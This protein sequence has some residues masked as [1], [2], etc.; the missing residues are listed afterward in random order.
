MEVDKLVVY[1]I[2]LGIEPR[3]GKEKFVVGFTYSFTNYKGKREDKFKEIYFPCG[4]KKRTKNYIYKKIY[5]KLLKK[6]NLKI[7]Y[8]ENNSV[9][10]PIPEE[11]YYADDD[12]NSEESEESESESESEESESEN[13]DDIESKNS[14]DI[15]NVT[16]IITTIHLDYNCSR[17]SQG[18]LTC[19]LGKNISGK[20]IYMENV[21]CLCNKNGDEVQHVNSSL[22]ELISNISNE[23]S[24]EKFQD[25]SEE[26]SK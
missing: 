6:Y 2:D 9:Y 24:R 18:S 13:D 25:I 20:Y 15:N 3:S 8:T 14:K 1:S 12:M 21:S 4:K 19:K 22:K 11:S 17:C 10:P 16:K 5:N 26:F 7:L 23:E